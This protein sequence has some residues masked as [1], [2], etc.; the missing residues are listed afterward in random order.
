MVLII[1]IVSVVI[2]FGLSL[3]VGRWMQ[4]K[5]TEMERHGKGDL[6]ERD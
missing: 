3:V 2:V 6:E 4:R 1:L 5:G